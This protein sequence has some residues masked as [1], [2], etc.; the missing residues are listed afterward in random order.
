MKSALWKPLAVAG[1]ALTLAAHLSRSGLTSARAELPS[2]EARLV[3][4]IDDQFASGVAS[5]ETAVNVN[6][7]TFNAAGVAA[8][9]D[10]YEPELKRLG[11]RTWRVDV[12]SV[13]RGVHLFATRSG[14]GKG[15]RLLLIGHLDTVF[16]TDSGFLKW[17]PLENGLARGPGAADMKGGNL[18]L[19][20]V[21]GALQSIGELEKM[22]VTVALTGDEENPGSDPDGSYVTT[23]G[24]LIELAKQADIAL[25]FESAKTN[26][27]MIKTARRG[28]STWSLK[29]AARGGHSS[30]IFGKDAG[31]GAIY[32]LNA[33]LNRFYRELRADNTLTYN[34]GNVAGGTTLTR[35][36][37]YEVSLEGKDNVIPITAQ[38]YGD[39]RFTTP[40]QLASARQSMKAIVEQELALI[41]L[42]YSEKAAITAEITF[43]DRYPPVVETPANLAL[44]KTLSQAS[45]SLGLGALRPFDVNGGAADSSF[46]APYVSAVLDG[47]GPLGI[48]THSV[49]EVLDTRTIPVAAKRAAVFLLRLQADSKK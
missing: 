48:D 47:L 26:M 2:A 38:A 9:A 36:S 31:P 24:P 45:E 20:Q 14:T 28:S 10:L 37:D 23:R 33:I 18:V 35:Q 3:K 29:V 5:L 25:G 15:P 19:L 7:G 22:N 21:L 16:E 4:Y 49:K 43:L 34:V 13:N 1:V 27:S 17:Q 12:K 41:N 39:L 6:S 42:D 32:P 44:L 11:F 30:T 46:A 8:V 40:E